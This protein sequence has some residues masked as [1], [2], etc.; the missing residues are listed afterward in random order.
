MYNF[1]PAHN[2]CVFSPIKLSTSVNNTVDKENI[3]IHKKFFEGTHPHG[4]R[5]ESPAR[6]PVAKGPRKDGRHSAK[7]RRKSMDLPHHARRT[8][9]RRTR[10]RGPRH[11]HKTVHRAALSRPPRR[12]SAPGARR[13]LHD[14]SRGR[15]KEGGTGK[16]VRIEAGAR[17]D[18]RRAEAERRHAGA[19]QSPA[20]A[21]AERHARRCAR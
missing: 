11:V 20:D 3:C 16:G 12:C 9:K 2:I 15:C 5:K 18:K 6:T 21:A 8:G 13:R 10:P 14:P 1:V 17:T 4:R 19:G 7:G